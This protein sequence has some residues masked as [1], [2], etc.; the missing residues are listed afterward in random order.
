MAWYQQSTHDRDTHRGT[1]SRGRVH[2][3]CGI[4]FTASGR[5]LRTGPPHPHQTC[6]DCGLTA[7]Q[8][9]EGVI[10]MAQQ[11]DTTPITGRRTGP[12]HDVTEDNAALGQET[13]GHEATPHSPAPQSGNVPDPGQPPVK[14]PSRSAPGGQPDTTT[15]ADPA[16]PAAH[17][18]RGDQP[19]EGR[20]QPHLGRPTSTV[21]GIPADPG[22]GY[23][24]NSPVPDPPVI[25]ADAAARVLQEYF[26]ANADRGDDAANDELVAEMLR[27]I[28]ARQAA[29]EDGC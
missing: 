6:L 15:P 2:T 18:D 1:V 25:S 19:S 20:E 27:R 14:R 12:A 26:L 22:Q 21:D 7:A 11:Q 28:R 3:A 9:G 29:P 8:T 23:P 16:S 13:R 5:A 24:V 4:Q 17:P 10:A